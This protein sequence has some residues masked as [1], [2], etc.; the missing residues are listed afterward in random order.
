MSKKSL[1][2]VAFALAFT[3]KSLATISVILQADRLE[4]HLGNPM[5]ATGLV[6][7]VVSTTNATFEALAP[8]SNT[9]VGQPLTAGGDDYVVYR[10]N[11]TSYGPGVLDA[12]LS[13]GSALNLASVAG[14]N[15][16][17]ALALMW[18]PSLNTASAQIPNG[19]RYNYYSNP[20]AADGS[21]PW[22]TPNDPTS[23]Y[24]LLFYTKS[25]SGGDLGPGPTASNDATVGRSTQ[26]VVPEP[27]T[28]GLAGLGL[29][30]RRRRK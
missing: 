19:T 5:P 22:V 27:T 26:T 2:A 16:G 28:I 17:D 21:Q 1:L 20:L 3:A 18:F 29:L 10:G 24:N 12:S 9:A 13:G 6:L 14:W 30:G 15:P 23:N 4:D 11:L 8:N 25:S 7:L